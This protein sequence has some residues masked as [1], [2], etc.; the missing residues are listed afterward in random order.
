[1]ALM[2]LVHILQTL[3]PAS[4]VAI[5]LTLLAPV[6]AAVDTSDFADLVGWTV[7]AST[8]VVGEFE[9]CDFDK[10]IRFT[11]G[12]VLTCAEYSYSYAYQPDAVIF[13]KPF[14]LAGRSYWMVKA[15]I[16]DEFFEMRP[17]PAK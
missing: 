4:H 5:A 2:A 10:R 15:L 8:E 6:A 17:I 12:W 14:S 11:N 3:R 1:M 9:G 13:T 16:D 7:T